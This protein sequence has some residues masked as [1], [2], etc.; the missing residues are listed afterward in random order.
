M[1]KDKPSKHHLRFFT[2]PSSIQGESFYS[3]DKELINQIKNVF[4]LKVGS[5][6]TVLDGSGAEY[7]VEIFSLGSTNIGGFVLSKKDPRGLSFKINL[8]CSILKGDRFEWI[9]Q[10]CTETGISGFYPVIY[11]NSIIKEISV[12]KKHRYEKILKEATEQSQ[13]GKIPFLSDPISFQEARAIANNGYGIAAIQESDKNIFYFDK[14]I[15]SKK[16]INIFVGPEG[17]FSDIE[18]EAMRRSGIGSFSMGEGILRSET[19]CI[20]ASGIIYQIM[21]K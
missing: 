17:D 13:R 5:K 7:I 12:N 20:L 3:N 6:I 16:E 11:K 2:E 15:K 4:R 21:L 8:F 10:K 14:E 19:A 9:L 18:K 1:D